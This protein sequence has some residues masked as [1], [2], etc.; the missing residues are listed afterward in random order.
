[1][2]MFIS[3]LLMLKIRMLEYCSRIV[4]L[5]CQTAE[6]ICGVVCWNLA[7]Q[8]SRFETPVSYLGQ[9]NCFSSLFI[10]DLV[11]LQEET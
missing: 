8:A 3:M 6:D 9:S 1:M 11:F 4:P 7:A 10:S 5:C 2:L